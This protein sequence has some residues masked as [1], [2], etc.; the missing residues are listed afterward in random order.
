MQSHE[1]IKN[2]REELG[3][4]QESFARIFDVSART[5]IRWENGSSEPQAGPKKRVR[6]LLELL[7]EPESAAILK[8]AA[9]KS[10]GPELLRNILNQSP[11]S[12]TPWFSGSS[13]ITPL[14]SHGISPI[15]GTSLLA[16]LG[17]VVGGAISAWGIYKELHKRFGSNATDS[18]NAAMP[19][20]K[21]PICDCTDNSRLLHCTGILA[22]GKA[23]TFVVCRKCLYSSKEAHEKLSPTCNCIEVPAFEPVED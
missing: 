2:A 20:F 18:G 7:R 17:K 3:L 4:S 13:G 23:C 8:E 1:E 22:D 14:V 21:C 10:D 15:A 6:Q 5:V 11:S 19:G 9:G 12:G 16:G